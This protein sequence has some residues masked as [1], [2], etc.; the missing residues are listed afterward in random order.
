MLTSEERVNHRRVRPFSQLATILATKDAKV[1]VIPHPMS[2]FT[3][4]RGIIWMDKNRQQPQS[5]AALTL[6]W[7]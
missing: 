2:A 6:Y 7:S 5:L 1:S 3:R 4:K